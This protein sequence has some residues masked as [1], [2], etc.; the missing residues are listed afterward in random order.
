MFVLYGSRENGLSTLHDIYVVVNDV[1]ITNVFTEEM[2]KKG[3]IKVLP[4]FIKSAAT[5]DLSNVTVGD[6][7]I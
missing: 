3:Q 5:N 6:K 1:M 4:Q 2:Q 7:N